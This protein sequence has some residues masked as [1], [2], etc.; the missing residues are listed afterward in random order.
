MAW[1]DI[2]FL[3]LVTKL[4]HSLVSSA[5]S[6]RTATLIVCNKVYFSVLLF[7]LCVFLPSTD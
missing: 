1:C 4:K 6:D 2:S 3:V 7:M 5:F